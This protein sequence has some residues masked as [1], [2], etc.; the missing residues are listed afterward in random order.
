MVESKHLTIYGN[1]PLIGKI[2]DIAKCRLKIWLMKT[3]FMDSFQKWSSEL[4]D[5]ISQKGKAPLGKYRAYGYLPQSHHWADV[6][7]D[8]K[9][10]KMII[11]KPVEETSPAIQENLNLNKDATLYPRI[12]E[13]QKLRD[14]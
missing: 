12:S 1:L 6:K 4:R 2:K 13:G 11:G 7:D 8:V 3:L 5:C 10:F 14:E 9:N